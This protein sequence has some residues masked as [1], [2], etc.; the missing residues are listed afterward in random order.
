MTNWRAVG[1]GLVVEVALSVVG[2]LAPGVGQFVAGLIGGFVAGYLARTTVVGGLWH[3]LLAG[4]LG[5]FLLAIPAGIIVSVA[6]IEIGLLGQFGGALAGLG[7][8][9]FVLVVAV[10]LGANSALGG[11]IGSLVDTGRSRRDAPS[12]PRDRSVDADRMAADTGGEKS[13]S[14]RLTDSILDDRR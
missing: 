4:S 3:G 12:S 8:A 13:S 7:T 6:S 5:G 10:V 1:I 9:L 11:A 2:L 14:P